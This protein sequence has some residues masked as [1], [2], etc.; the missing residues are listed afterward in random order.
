MRH[1][2]IPIRPGLALAAATL[3]SALSL[4]PAF[5]PT[6]AAAQPARA[7]ADAGAAARTASHGQPLRAEIRRT[8]D[9]IP[10]ILAKNW[11]SL[12]FGYGFA[13]AQDNLCTMAN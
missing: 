12:G 13:F 2:F 8:A 3:L 6:P 9:G 1:S 4:A 7:S 5:T 10:H 11:T